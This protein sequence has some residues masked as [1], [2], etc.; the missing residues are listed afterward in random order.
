MNVENDLN[1]E[2]VIYVKY[3]EL[4]ILKSK[5]DTKV[6]QVDVSDFRFTFT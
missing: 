2:Q 1:V 4:N 3:N 6:S 5:T